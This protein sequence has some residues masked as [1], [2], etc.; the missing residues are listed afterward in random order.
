MCVTVDRLLSSDLVPESHIDLIKIDTEGAERM[1]LQGMRQTIQSHPYPKPWMLIEVGWGNSRKDW[2]EELDAFQMLFD[3][4]YEPY[5]L[6]NIRGTTMHWMTPK[7]IVASD[8]FPKWLP[9]D[10]ARKKIDKYFSGV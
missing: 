8:S 9:D 1:V 5:D 10:E 4:G 6:S 2:Q 7:Q 3:N